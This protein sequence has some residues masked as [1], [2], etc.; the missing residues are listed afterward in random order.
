MAKMK[1]GPAVRTRLGRWEIPAADAYRSVFI[2]LED[3]AALLHSLWPATRILEIGCGDGSFGER[4]LARYT[5]ASY[6][7]IDISDTPG[8]LFRGD[9]SRATFHRI[10]SSDYLATSPGQFDLVVLVDVVHHVP[11]DMRRDLLLDLQRLTAPGGHY[12]VKDW[13]PTRTLGHY[14]AYGA[15]RYITGDQISHVPLE[16]MKADLADWLG[17]PMRIEARIPPR[18][19][20]YLLGY[21]RVAAAQDVG[22]TS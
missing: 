17:D 18:R 14:A 4:L 2:N 21:Q 19:N 16:K 20:N 13:E 15:D 3:C 12:V 5:E 6:V 1:L 10:S 22:T 11:L 8:R 9:A 7:G